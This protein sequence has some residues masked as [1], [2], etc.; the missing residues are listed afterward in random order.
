MGL[1]EQYVSQMYSVENF[2]LIIILK[3]KYYMNTIYQII[4]Y[5]LY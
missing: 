3:H 2:L 1:I 5:A 4:C